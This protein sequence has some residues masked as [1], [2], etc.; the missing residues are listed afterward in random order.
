MRCH[1]HVSG[2][3]IT[4]QQSG[5]MYDTNLDPC[6]S[7]LAV[8]SANPG[9]A[10]C[11]PHTRG[12]AELNNDL[13]FGSPVVHDPGE[14][15]DSGAPVEQAELWCGADDGADEGAAG[16]CAEGVGA[17]GSQPEHGETAGGEAPVLSEVSY[18]QG[19]VYDLQPAGQ[20]HDVAAPE[21][22]APEAGDLG[23]WEPLNPDEVVNDNKPIRR[24]VPKIPKC[25]SFH[26]LHER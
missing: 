13:G 24:H 20:T 9:N 8:D 19:E 22:G 15:I 10:G 5:A 26:V 4:L 3:L 16:W 17:M 12:T 7:S 6:S 21:A 11:P 1:A 2:M 25:A 23:V 18:R 14:T